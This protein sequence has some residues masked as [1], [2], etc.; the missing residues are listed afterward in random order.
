MAEPDPNPERPTGAT[1]QTSAKKLPKR[2]IGTS[3]LIRKTHTEELVVA[4]CGALGTPLHELAEELA[5][6]LS[7]QYRYECKVI[8]L[9]DF[10]R[11]YA[12]E[13]QP[14]DS[15]ARVRWL[16]KKGN[17][18]RENHG[19]SILADLA[20]RRISLDREDAQREAVAAGGRYTG[21]RVCHI[22]DSI[23]NVE[24]LEALRLLYRELFFCI[25]VFAPMKAREKVLTERGMSKSDLYDLVDKDSG[26]EFDHGQTVRKAFPR[27]DYFLRASGISRSERKGRVERFLDVLFQMGGV[28]P[29]LEETAMYH[30][31]AAARGSS[32][33]SRQVGAAVTNE[34]GSLLGVGWN[35]VPS[36]GGGVY[37]SGHEHHCFGW[38][39]LCHNDQEK[40]DIANDLISRLTKK[41]F[42]VAN[43]DVAELRKI[44]LKSRVG[45]LIEFS[46]A[47]HAE[48]NAILNA[49]RHSGTE[50][51]GGTLYCTTYPC[52]S[53]ARTLI[54]AGIGR[55]FFI[56]P[57]PKSL[58]MKLHSDALAEEDGDSSKVRILPYEGIAPA[59]YLELFAIPPAGRKKDG[60]ALMKQ[61]LDVVPTNRVTLEALPALEGLVVTKIPSSLPTS[62]EPEG[63]T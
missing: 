58:A 12:G 15:A 54:A 5:E 16:I 11:Q 25:G 18:I 38:Q 2:L 4:L 42:V 27:S 61:R 14:E 31:A 8:R 62:N 6:H 13:P 57:Y 44:I 3:E 34:A 50:A 35:D 28:T 29:T 49:L 24:E 43:S 22:I 32:C 1:P 41:G 60:K 52:H 20:I 9:S 48:V 45:Q 36:A 56:E 10:I 55:V 23:K 7:D 21:R 30:A 53:C 63:A 26:E 47:V 39:G 40:Q 37:L 19:L 51:V 59:R 17:E 33:L 46:R